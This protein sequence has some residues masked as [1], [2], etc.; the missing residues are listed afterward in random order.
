MSTRLVL[1][2]CI[3]AALCWLVA[4][5]EQLHHDRREAR[6]IPTGT[7]RRPQPIPDPLR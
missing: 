6:A 7:T 5:A 2:L 3:I 1:A 4:W